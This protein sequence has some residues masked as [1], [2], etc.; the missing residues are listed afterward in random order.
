MLILLFFGISTSLLAKEPIEVTIYH[1]KNIFPYSYEKKR[2][3]ISA[4]ELTSEGEPAGK[5]EPISAE[6]LAGEG[7]PAG[8]YTEVVK[9]IFANMKGYNIKIKSVSWELG[10]HLIK[11]GQGFAL[12]PPFRRLKK[13]PYIRL[14]SLPIL[15]Q[16]NVVFCTA[17]TLKTP[18]PEW[19]EDYYGLTFGNDMNS[20]VGG[21][22]FSNAITEGKIK[23]IEKE[24]IISNLTMLAN[25][26]IDC[27]INEE[28]SVLLAWQQ[29]KEDK[30][31]I[32]EKHADFVQGATISKEPGYLAFTS[33]DDDK[34]FFKI[35]FV[36]QFNYE[37][38]K[39]KLSGEIDKIIK[40][41]LAQYKV[42]QKN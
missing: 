31:Y 1:D 24:D 29:M 27:H 26:E 17:E 21:E 14:Y 40:T 39:L 25:R 11:T 2:E 28:L 16:T 41:F 6:E 36:T 33:N 13:R 23:L 34:F 10:T 5:G 7:E 22:R 20:Q 18:R 38:I 15:E 42:I 30:L 9:K 4:E 35:D 12:Y 19:P 3:P 37:L 32:P 8:L